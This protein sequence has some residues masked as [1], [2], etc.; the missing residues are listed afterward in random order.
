VDFLEQQTGTE[1]S[2]L[3]QICRYIE[4]HF[5][6]KLTLEQLA[7]KCECSSKHIGDVERGTVSASWPLAVKIGKALNTGVDYYL[8]DTSDQYFDIQIDVEISNILKDCDMET[9]MAIRDTARRIAE[10]GKKIQAKNK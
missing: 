6:E 3:E 7:E 8:A 1:P 10:Y 4:R 2:S 5:T 9:R